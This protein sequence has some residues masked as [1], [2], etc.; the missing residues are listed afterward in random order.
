MASFTRVR[1][2]AFAILP[3]FFRKDLSNLQ[4]MVFYLNSCWVASGLW[5]G[6][7][8]VFTTREPFGSFNSSINNTKYIISYLL[9]LIL[10]KSNVETTTIRSVKQSICIQK[11][12]ILEYFKWVI[13]GEIMN[14]YY[15]PTAYNFNPR[16]GPKELKLRFL[17]KT[18]IMK[19]DSI[20]L[21]KDLEHKKYKT[22]C[23]NAY[24][25]YHKC[26]QI[27]YFDRAICRQF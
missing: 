1:K 2:S 11:L 24:L 27:N 7:G 21:G 14:F 3:S 5:G 20:P 10:I 16:Q 9:S 25:E 18:G 23:R 19:R 13:C 26:L 22:A 8:R 6:K 12:Y 17:I 15:E 4:S